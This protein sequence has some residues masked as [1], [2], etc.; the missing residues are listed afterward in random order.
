MGCRDGA[1]SGTVAPGE[2]GRLSHACGSPGFCVTCYER[3]LR[4]R[5]RE[6]GTPEAGIFYVIDGDLWLNST[7]IPE[8]RH[9]REVIIQPGN[10]RSSW[11]NLRRMIRPLEGVP[12][13]CYPR[14][15]AVFVKATGKY[16]LYLGPELLTHE[17]L[18][19]HVMDAMALPAA[20]TE[21]RLARHFRIQSFLMHVPAAHTEVQLGPQFRTQRFP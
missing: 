3:H 11:T 12:H 5:W 1:V 6:A 17:P 16:H 2:G 10:H 13:E 15:R 8:A 18:I 14:G 4:E 9:L 19:R 7:P 20:Q 21:V